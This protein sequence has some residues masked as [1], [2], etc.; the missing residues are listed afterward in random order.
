MPTARCA[1][2]LRF[3]LSNLYDFNPET[4]CVGP[5]AL[6]EI[7]RWALSKFAQVS[8]RVTLAYERYEFHAIYHALHNF[9]GTTVSSIYMDV[10]KDRLYCSLPAGPERRAAQTVI[11]R[12]LDGL[13]RLMSPILCFTTAEAWEHLHGLAQNAPLE[14]SIFFASFASVDDVAKDDAF[15]EQWNKLLSLRSG[16]T[17]VLEAARRDKVI[18][19]GLDAEVV[20]RLSDEW[21]TFLDGRLGQLE[22]LCIVSSLRLDTGESVGLSFVA[23]ETIPGVEIAVSPAPGNKCERCWT[24][25]TTVGED[26]EHPAICARCAAVVRQLTA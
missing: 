17:R 11:Y 10:L 6:Q 8:R 9:C 16:I 24:I 7:D 25:S 5:E 20:L 2:H 22:E 1:T 19:L 18:G 15:D 13:L 3:L 12:I 4:D 26:A 23:D 14:Q 21:K